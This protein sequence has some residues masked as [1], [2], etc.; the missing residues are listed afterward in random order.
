MV[1]KTWGMVKNSQT[2][3]LLCEPHEKA[4]LEQLEMLATLAGADS[5]VAGPRDWSGTSSGPVFCSAQATAAV[6][7]L[8]AGGT[9]LVRLQGETSAGTQTAPALV[10]PADEREVLGLMLRQSGSAFTVAVRGLAVGINTTVVAGLLAQALAVVAGGETGDER[11]REHPRTPGQRRNR[12]RGDRYATVRDS[13]RDGTGHSGTAS[14]CWVD[15]S[16]SY[17]PLDA[18]VSPV[19]GADLDW[20]AWQTTGQIPGFR[21]AAGLPAWEN[22]ALLGGSG[23]IVRPETVPSVLND[24]AGIF[25]CIVL[26]LGS[27]GETPTLS[28]TGTTR[29]TAGAD[30]VV[31]VADYSRAALL[32]WETLPPDLPSPAHL[33]IV[34]GGGLPPRQARRALREIHPEITVSDW[35]HSTR[36]WDSFGRDGLTAPLPRRV[37]HLTENF[38]AGLLHLEQRTRR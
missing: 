2:V 26:D 22:V 14:V 8:L 36:I 25:P 9:Y 37:A 3:T 19:S 4:W 33:I 11:T 34:P 24:L 31:W 27:R 10:L 18:W 6:P 17:L 21:A 15:A 5:R 16:G 20:S 38:A 13:L 29:G 35:S 1:A 23:F 32:A 7:E 28:G 12:G 30:A